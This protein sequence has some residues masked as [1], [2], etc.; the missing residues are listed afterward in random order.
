MKRVF[1]CCFK[2]SLLLAMILSL[3]VS[4]LAAQNIPGVLGTEE[5]GS[6]DPVVKG[7]SVMLKASEAA[8]DYEFKF[9]IAATD[10]TFSPDNGDP[11]TPTLI[12]LNQSFILEFPGELYTYVPSVPD[13]NIK[14][15]VSYLQDCFVILDTD[16]GIMVDF[17]LEL[18]AWTETST[19]ITLR[20][21]ADLKDNT[22]YSV[23]VVDDK[24]QIGVRNVHPLGNSDFIYEA[25]AENAYI[26]EDKTPPM[27]DADADAGLWE[28]GYYVG[29]EETILT[30]DFLKLDFTEPVKPGTGSIYIYTWNG[31]VVDTI[32]ASALTIDASDPSIVIVGGVSD[33]IIGEEYYVI[34]QSGAITDLT[35]NSFEGVDEEDNWAFTVEEDLV[36]DLIAYMPTGTNIGLETDLV[37]EYD[38]AVVPGTAGTIN[39]YLEDGTL[40]QS[41]DVVSDNIHF[42]SIG[43]KVYIEI[44][45]LLPETSYKVSVD[46]GAFVSVAGEPA[47]AISS[48]DWKFV[49]E[50]N[51][52]PLLVDLTPDDNSVEVP[53]DQIFVMDFDMDVQA[54]TGTLELH[55]KDGNNTTILT[56]AAT[57]S[58]VTIS[59]SKVSIDFNGVMSDG[60]E[61]YIIVYPDFVQNTTYTPEPFAG[62]TKVFNWNFTTAIEKNAPE[63]VAL[64]PDEETISDNHPNLVMTFNE[65]VELSALG[66]NA[67][68][69]KVGDLTPALTIP[70][71]ADMF[72]GTKVSIDYDAAELGAGL[73]I[74]TDYYV[75]IDAGAIQDV[76]DNAF[77]GIADPSV[78][79]FRTG[80]DYV[81]AVGDELS[82]A[83]Q[84]AVYPNPFNDV[85]HISNYQNIAKIYITNVVGQRVIE[86]NNVTGIINTTNLRNG[87]YFI[88]L[89][90]D[91]DVIASTQRIVK[92]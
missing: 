11:L 70:L 45:D 18:T 43:K 72:S 24:L 54:G 58:R 81:L 23:F 91:D 83:S 69:Y 82:D 56:I 79:T 51:V 38:I 25:Y 22:H 44:D 41:L 64:D 4:P 62:I 9:S 10:V 7:K 26:T 16:Q 47:A 2:Q 40:V 46:A 67:Y 48:D 31:L 50:S 86:I 28:D 34:V 63:V 92:R 8:I 61:Y 49:T 19:V 87:I 68:V 35:G 71:T 73:D 76:N 78:W 5:A 13:N 30:N 88:T 80:S 74:N 21:T 39:I 14:V 1:T 65:N 90:L 33:L 27:L 66:G 53:L 6:I 85:I 3:M 42:S 20:P 59:G 84:Y 89:M 60:T 75:L 32:D 29:S 37:I 17:T 36:P 77:A 57:D 55:A 52:A 12:L 15:D